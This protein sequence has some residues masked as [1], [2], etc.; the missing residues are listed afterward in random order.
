MKALLKIQ[1]NNN[2]MIIKYLLK[3]IQKLCKPKKFSIIYF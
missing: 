2:Y 1:K 3:F